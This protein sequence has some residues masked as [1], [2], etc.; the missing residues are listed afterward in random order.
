VFRTTERG[1]SGCS[2]VA[3]ISTHF[4]DPAVV[5]CCEDPFPAELAAFTFSSSGKV[6]GGHT[7]HAVLLTWT[8]YVEEKVNKIHETFKRTYNL[9]VLIWLSRNKSL[10]KHGKRRTYLTCRVV[11]VDNLRKVK[12]SR[13]SRNIYETCI[14]HVLIWL[15]RNKSLIKHGSIEHYSRITYLIFAAF[16]A[17]PATCDG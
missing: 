8:I 5:T 4:E 14:L 12:S 3:G 1:A 2:T 6:S 15:F 9:H 7:S 11:D 17:P 13:C 16:L 10:I